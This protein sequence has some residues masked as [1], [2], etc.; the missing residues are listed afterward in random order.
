MSFALF[1]LLLH[2]A[3]ER[4]PAFCIETAQVLL[5]KTS[6]TGWC[7]CIFMVSSLSW[8][9]TAAHTSCSWSLLPPILRLAVSELLHTS[10]DTHS[11]LFPPSHL[12]AHCLKRSH[13][14]ALPPFLPPSHPTYLLPTCRY[15]LCS[16]HTGFGS[17]CSQTNRTTC[18]QSFLRS[19]ISI[20]Y[21]LPW[22]FTFF[23]IGFAL[24]A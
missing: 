9:G 11:I 8:A 14:T 22:V 17:F 3:L 21:S 20:C 12:L 19:I 18:A 2:P 6:L 16:C 15:L 23:F 10:P 4:V 24:S 7:H 13:C 5:R 1:S